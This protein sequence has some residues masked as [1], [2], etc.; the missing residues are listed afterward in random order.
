MSENATCRHCGD[1]VISVGVGAP[2][3]WCMKCA[4][5]ES[6][7]CCTAG[8]GR[9]YAHLGEHMRTG[10][11]MRCC[12]FTPVRLSVK[13]CLACKRLVPGTRNVKRCSKCSEVGPRPCADCGDSFQPKTRSGD[14]GT[15]CKPCRQKRRHWYNNNPGLPFPKPTSI[16]ECVWC[17]QPFPASVG[18]RWCSNECRRERHVHFVRWGRGDVCHL[19]KCIECDAITSPIA[20][21]SGPARCQQCRALNRSVAEARRR[22]VVSAGDTK[23][24]WRTVGERDG[25]VCHLCDRVVRATAGGADRPDGATVDHLIPISAGGLH[26]WKNVALAHRSCNLKRGAT[27]LAQLRLVG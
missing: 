11:H 13:R 14:A 3:K 21:Y 17:F 4:P 23:I 27:G 22:Q 25:W 12:G 19:A 8:F 16:T 6:E 15:Y 9:R 2:R 5:T 26:E 18:R 20:T 1:V 10:L 24:G 7:S